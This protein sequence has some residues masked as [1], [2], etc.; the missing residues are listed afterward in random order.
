MKSFSPK[1][2]VLAAA[3]TLGLGLSQHSANAFVLYGTTGSGGTASSLYTIDA[4]TGAST[5]VGAI[6]FNEV[7]SIDF[8]P[9]S[10]I[11]Y[12][13]SN[14]SRALITINTTTGAGTLVAALSPSFQSPDMTFRP[15]GVLYSWSEP[16]PDHLNSINLTTGATT[17]LGASGLGTANTG[18]DAN[19]AGTIHMKNFDGNV[20]TIDHT[21]GAATFLVSLYTSLHGFSNVLAF[22]PTDRL[23]SVNRTGGDSDLYT[24]DLTTGASTLVG[25][26]GLAN[27]A[28]LAFAPVP[29]AAPDAG[30]GTVALLGLGLAGLAFV[31][32]RRR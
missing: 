19:S 14:A 25:A 2:I 20:Y 22:D 23:Y 31:R 11:L 12:G 15:S 3:L 24:L 1:N 5:L 7:V 18:L 9:T 6:G 17:D 8:D 26:T 27:L 30:A 10:G 21:T 13:I 16:G 29:V 28:A 4:S 32:G